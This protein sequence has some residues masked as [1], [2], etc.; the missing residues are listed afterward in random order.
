[1]YDPAVEQLRKFGTRWVSIVS[2]SPS[3]KAQFVCMCCGRLSPTPDKICSSGAVVVTG[4]P[5][6]P[7]RYIKCEEWEAKNR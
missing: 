3:G 7:R 4:E 1:M 2:T 6:P 5:L